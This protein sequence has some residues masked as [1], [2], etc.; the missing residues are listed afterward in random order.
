[1]STPEK[2][3]IIAAI[4]AAFLAGEA[5]MWFL[6]YLVAAEQALFMLRHPVRALDGWLYQAET[7]QPQAPAITDP[8]RK[9]VER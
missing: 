1:M 9:Q 7:I 5:A 2:W 6:W 3:H 8:A 4:V